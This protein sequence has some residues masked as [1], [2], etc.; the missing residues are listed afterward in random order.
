M[1]IVNKGMSIGWSY[2]DFEKDKS[3]LGVYLISVLDCIL[4]PMQGDVYKLRPQYQG[5]VEEARIALAHDIHGLAIL[6][7]MLLFIFDKPSDLQHKD[8]MYVMEIVEKYF[9]NLRSI[10]DFM[11]KVLRLAVEESNIGKMSFDSLNSLMAFTE[12]NTKANELLP[13][14]LILLLASIKSEFNLI[15]SIRD[16][17]IHSGKQISLLKDQDGY[18]LGPFNDDGI[19]IEF[20]SGENGKYEYLIPY[21]SQRTENMLNFGE[22]IGR[23]IHRE[24]IRM[25]GEFPFMLCAL[26]GVCIPSFV[27]LLGR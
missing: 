24:F 25:H 13:E 2:E 27:K 22:E 7:D 21:L 3:V 5:L 15:K 18:K 10:Y 11:S 6:N 19:L 16:F 14:D 4:K 23:I 9:M 1:M 20:L 17:I 8:F 12:K 26:E